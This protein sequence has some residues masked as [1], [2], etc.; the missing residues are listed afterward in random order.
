MN[1]VDGRG[2]PIDRPDDDQEAQR[3]ESAAV[4]KGGESGRLRITVWSSGG[5]RLL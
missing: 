4:D 2:E 5:G 1:F 3:E